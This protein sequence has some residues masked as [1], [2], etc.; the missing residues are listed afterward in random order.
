MSIIAVANFKGGVAKT[1]T[2]GFMHNPR[3]GVIQI[4]TDETHYCLNRSFL[5][6]STLMLCAS[7]LWLRPYVLLVS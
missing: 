1:T 2:G 5:T 4:E 3:K 7:K 6:Q